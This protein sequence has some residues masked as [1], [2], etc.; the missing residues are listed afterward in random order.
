MT[1]TR[2]KL[3]GGLSVTPEETVRALTE[4]YTLHPTTRVP[5][6]GL[7]SLAGKPY[8]LQDHFPFEPLY[9]IARPKRILWKC[10]RQIAK[11]TNLAADAVL[12][13]ASTPNFRILFLC[14]RFEQVKRLSS[15]YVRP[16]IKHS[17]IRPLL[18]DE[19][20]VQAV[21]Q[22]T[23]TNEAVMYF[24]FALLDCERVR[25][26]SCEMINFDEIQ[27]LSYDFIPVINECMS[28]SVDYGISTYSGTPK[29]LDNG[30]EALWQDS[31]KAEWVTPC[32]CG[33]WS[34]ASMQ[35]DLVKMM[36]K[37]TVICPKCQK[38][39]NPRAGH[40]RHTD[41]NH[42]DFPGYHI[43]QIIMPMHYEHPHKWQELLLKMRGGLNYTQGKFMNEVLGESADSGVKLLTQT[44]IQK[45]SVLGKNSFDKCVLAVRNC[46]IRV[47]SV[48]WGGYGK[49]ETSYT[50]ATI[51]GLNERTGNIECHFT[52]RFSA[53]FTHE[54][55]AKML[56][57][58]YLEAGCQY[59]AHDYGG[60][61]SVRETLMIQ[62]GLPID[63][64]MGFM[65][66]RASVHDMVRYNP[67]AS[68]SRGYWTLDKARTLVMQAV[69]IKNGK[70]LLPEY[71]SSKEITSDLLNMVE[72]KHDSAGGSD[73]YL[74][75]RIPKMSDDFA[76][77]LNYAC[78][79]IWHIT[80]HYPN[81]AELQKFA[82]S[83]EQL[84]SISPTDPRY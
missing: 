80:Q 31:S 25:G 43:P 26:I 36:G 57:K 81:V 41:K 1:S 54:E 15:N 82:L 24:S 70:V 61:G 34:M 30:I 38:P 9:K 45:A 76:H 19:T 64:I 33:H 16:F 49:D 74:I 40:W 21:L 62:A 73:V 46:K 28:A 51:S 58:F 47:L 10:A 60:S 13:V 2:A 83:P 84:N 55:E 67:S 4:L 8:T 27:D 53:G 17:L 29:T 11:T 48:D 77:A 71:T 59:F 14:P 32:S 79:A 75:R 44:D 39:L 7:L 42:L 3:R 5:L 65:Y 37:N 23:F 12:S 63:R 52:Y 6:L 22:R 69:C 68:D 20:S 72:D 50:V 35:A 18:V 78:I 66:V 56:L